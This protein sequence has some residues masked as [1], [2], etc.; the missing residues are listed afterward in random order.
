MIPTICY[1][2]TSS[3][4][5]IYAAMAS[6]SATAVRRLYPG[7]HIVLLCDE[8]TEPRLT[9]KNAAILSL[10][11]RVVRVETGIDK[12]GLR[13][14]FVK[15]SM[16]QIID[17]DFVFLDADVVPVR[18]FDAIAS[19]RADVAA[20][21]D[22]FH[23]GQNEWYSWRLLLRHCRSHPGPAKSDGIRGV[24][25][26]MG[27]AFPTRLYLNTGVIFFRDT[28]A[29]R[30]LGQRWHERWCQASA[31]G[32]HMDQFAFN[33]SLDSLPDVK[34]RVLPYRYNAMVRFSP[35]FAHRAKLLHFHSMGSGPTEDT[36]MFALAQSVMTA[37]RLDQERFDR[38]MRT[39][40]PWLDEDM[41]L[42]RIAAGNYLAAGGVAVKRL[43]GRRARPR[44]AAAPTPLPAEQDR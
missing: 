11:D 5:D 6:I 14:R 20:A 7:A 41:F 2:L 15:T 3:G 16:R 32:H 36:A 23:V 27:W 10:T 34:P 18:G 4:D 39:G 21:R 40:Y 9:Q 37:G 8:V 24:Y 35:W 17:G 38:L 31:A 29:A 43:L 1:V 19:G 12:P 25:R 30:R 33:S 44:V 42:L 22:T 26:E 13:S 28:P